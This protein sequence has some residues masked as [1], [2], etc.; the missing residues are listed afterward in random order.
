MI[1]FL[2]SPPPPFAQLDPAGALFVRLFNHWMRGQTLAAAFAPLEGKRVRICLTDAPLQ[3]NVR[4][5][6]G[7]LTVAPAGEAPHVTVRARLAD[8]ARLATRAE[9][10]DTLFFQRR[11]SIEG[12]T[13]TG[14]AIK[15]ALDALEWDWRRHC[16]SILPLGAVQALRSL[17]R[18]LRRSPLGPFR[19]HRSPH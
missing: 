11:L 3:L 18:R 13:E 10:P 2:P 12:Q 9:D 8:F 14:L 4:I 7:Q 1:S 5:A 6:A 17:R 16:E 19:R 15:N